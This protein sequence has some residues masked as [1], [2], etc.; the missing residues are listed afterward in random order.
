MEKSNQVQQDNGNL[1]I[2]ER[3]RCVPKEAKKEIE[4]GRLKG[5]HD[6]NPMWRIKALTE[7][8]G[9]AGFGWYT[10]II[11]T[12]TEASE[13][14]E[15]AV[16][17]DINLFVKKDGEWSRP[18][19]GN[20]GNKLIANEKK[21]ENG[22][23]VY[24]PYLDDDA[25]KKAYTD[26]ISVAAKALGVGADVYFVKDKGKYASEAKPAAESVAQAPVKPILSS[27]GRDW[28][29]AVAFTAS[30]SD[31]AEV[32]SEK[33]RSKYDITNDDLELL[34]KQSGKKS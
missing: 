28:K 32:I 30:Q 25:Y 14:G 26:A 4:A 23:Q 17:V 9:P 20:G 31:S 15:M 10:E 13:S 18:I 34:L 8:F 29:A 5:K 11:R 19:F 12:W 1:S 7:V 33:I 16:F 21:Y 2:Y 22:Q 3:V 24:I 6:I 27:K